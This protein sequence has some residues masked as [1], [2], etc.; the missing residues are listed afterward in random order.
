MLLTNDLILSILFMQRRSARKMAENL[1][2]VPCKDDSN[3][4]LH[5]SFSETSDETLERECCE[6]DIVKS[7]ENSVTNT[8]V[9]DG[10]WCDNLTLFISVFVFCFILYAVTAYPDQAP[11]DSGELVAAAY[12]LG[13]GHPPGYPLFC[14]IGKLWSIILPFGTIAWR[15]NIGNAVAGAAAAATVSLFGARFS[16]SN[17]AGA[18]AGIGFGLCPVVWLFATQAEVFTLNNLFSAVLLYL[19][20]KF[21]EKPSFPVAAAGAFS[22]GLGLG[23]Q[24]TLVIYAVPLCAA[25]LFVG[26]WT[27]DIHLKRF[28][29]LAGLFLLGFSVYIYMPLATIRSP[30]VSWGECHTWEGFQKHF[31][32]KEYV[33]RIIHPQS[34]QL[35]FFIGMVRFVCRLTKLTAAFWKDC[36]FM[37]GM[38]NAKLRA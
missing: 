22:S 21:F 14:I 33:C 5:N 9:D 16:R 37:P 20:L 6:S 25:V 10:Q 36:G 7:H 11:G 26:L 35:M 19:S 12:Q 8:A 18:L 1:P 24:H 30:Y 3:G 31:L 15:M 13:L 17:V 32:R 28:F 2:E 34:G 4:A 38:C 23:N 29:A 27:G